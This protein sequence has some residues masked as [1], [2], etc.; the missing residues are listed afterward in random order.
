MSDVLFV[1]NNFPAQFGAV[2]DALAKAGHRCVAIASRTGR[3]IDGVRLVSW[4]TGRGST[5]DILREATRIEADLIRGRAAAEQ[6]VKLRDEG[7][8]PAIIIG[9]PGWGET[10][11]LREIFPKARQIVYAEYYYRLKGGDVGFDP[12]FEDPSVDAPYLLYAKNAGMALAFSEAAAIVTPTPFQKSLLPEMFQARAEVIHEGI[13][14]DAIAPRD[15]VELK[16]GSGLVLNRSMPIITFIN[17]RFEPLRGCHIFM[18]AL[19]RL[20]TEIPDAR[21][22]LIGADE[23]GGYGKPAEQGQVWGQKFLSEVAGKVDRS[24]LHFTGR[25]PHD[26]MLSALAVSSAHVYYTYPFVLSWSMLEAMASG[27]LVLG[28]DTAPVRDAITDGVNGR[29]NDFFD[30]DALSTAMIEAC[31]DNSRFDALRLNARRTIIERYDQKRLCLPDWL[32]L[33]DRLL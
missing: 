25:V 16:L 4:N 2:A 32:K 26:I 3:A 13:D 21:V 29:L 19:P 10:T 5:K 30:V 27:C 9:H 20:M 22:L 23:P 7:F 15:N 6:A 11:Y 28:S 14:T 1:H 24:R 31:R 8:D 17:R 12:E 33:I 18:R